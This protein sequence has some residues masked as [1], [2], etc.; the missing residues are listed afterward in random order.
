VAAIFAAAVICVITAAVAGSAKVAACDAALASV[1]CP[2]PEL[3]G[4]WF[5]APVSKAVRC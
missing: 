1:A 3:P 4:A 5:A 2:I